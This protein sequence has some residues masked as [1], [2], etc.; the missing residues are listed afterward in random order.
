MA[1]PRRSSTRILSYDRSFMCVTVAASIPWCCWTS[2]GRYPS[3]LT[4]YWVCVPRDSIQSLPAGRGLGL[5]SDLCC[6]F[7]SSSPCARRPTS[8]RTAPRMRF[9]SSRSFGIRR[10]APIAARLAGSLSHSSLMRYF[11]HTL[12]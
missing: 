3:N 11:V 12:S 7:Y 9:Q 2:F 8:L 4:G 1:S 10:R 5:P 6:Q